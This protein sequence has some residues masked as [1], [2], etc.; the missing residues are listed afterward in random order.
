MMRIRMPNGFTNA[1]QL[2]TI[3]E[4]SRD[5]GTGFVDI[6]TRQQIQLRGFAIG[7]LPYIWD[8]LSAVD[9]VSLQTGMDNIRNVVGCP[10]A[11][12]RHE[13]F[14]A[15]PVVREFTEAFLRN[16]AFTNLPR[17]FNVAITACTENCT[18]A[19]T[20]DLALTP[21]I[22]TLAGE[23][24]KGFNIAVGGKIGS[25]GLRLASPLD[26]FARPEDGRRSAATSRC[27]SATMAPART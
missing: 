17:K 12:L 4:L 8:R 11:G 27:C 13:L 19:E 3:G 2:R 1:A 23:E 15:S 14:D 16:K 24:V 9:L 25:G 20:Q 18:H 22:K 5:C 21:A 7:D 10:V 6:T 26:V